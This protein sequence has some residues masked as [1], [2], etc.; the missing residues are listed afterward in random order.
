[1]KVQIEGRD[2]FDDASR[3][4]PSDLF[5]IVKGESSGNEYLDDTVY[6]FVR[7]DGD[8]IIYCRLDRAKI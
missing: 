2:Y 4:H 5:R 8:Y 7:H 6:M 1:M 3:L